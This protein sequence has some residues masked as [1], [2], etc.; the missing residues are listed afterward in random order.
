MVRRDTLVRPD[1]AARALAT[2]S[3]PHTEHCS[4]MVSVALSGAARRQLEAA[5]L[6]AKFDKLLLIQS[7]R[8]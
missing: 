4:H 2:H 7:I 1:V 6:N 3:M 5:A 8:S